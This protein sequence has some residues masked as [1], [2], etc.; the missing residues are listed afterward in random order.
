MERG[1]QLRQLERF[2]EAVAVL[3]APPAGSYGVNASKIAMFA[4]RRDNQVQ[5][6]A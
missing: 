2:D 5:K 1:E 4:Q 6:L 3:A